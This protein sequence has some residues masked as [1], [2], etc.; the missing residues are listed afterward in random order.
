MVEVRE[1]LISS[2][3]YYYIQI[4]KNGVVYNKVIGKTKPKDAS[5]AKLALEKEIKLG[6]YDFKAN[7][8]AIL[9]DI[10]HK[11][12]YLPESELIKV[13]KGLNIPA[14]DV[15]GV[16]TFYSFF[17]LSLPAKHVIKVCDGTACHVRG[18]PKIINFLE[19]SLGISP[20]ETTS[21]NLFTIET[22]RCLGLCASAPLMTVDGVL[23]PKLTLESTKNIL[24]EIKNV[25]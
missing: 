7:A 12:N 25:E 2:F 18:S 5:K 21:D 23:H 22:V 8:V 10:Q 13:S 24:G 14:V 16:A 19:K 6:K 1:L 17:S 20:G 15:Y 11:Y 9:E 3:T 4:I